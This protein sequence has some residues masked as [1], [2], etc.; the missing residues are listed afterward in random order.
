MCQMPLLTSFVRLAFWQN[1]LRWCSSRETHLVS[2]FVLVDTIT[3]TVCLSVW[4]RCSKFLCEPMLVKSPGRENHRIQM[5]YFIRASCVQFKCGVTWLLCVEIGA[6]LRSHAKFTGRTCASKLWSRRHV[7]SVN[8]L[9]STRLKE[10]FCS[11]STI[12]Q[13]ATIAR[14]VCVVNATKPHAWTWQV[15]YARFYMP[16][17][18]AFNQML[19]SPKTRAC[20][21]VAVRET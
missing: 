12:R 10:A 1:V 5:S 13:R 9:F 4:L 15:S 2:N 19:C 21:P 14:Q 20:C 16:E 8:H 17:Q 18:C 7:P 11:L 3:C 6:P